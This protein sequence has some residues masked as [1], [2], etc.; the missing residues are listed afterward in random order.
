MNDSNCFKTKLTFFKEIYIEL[1]RVEKKIE[2]TLKIAL[3]SPKSP[4]FFHFLEKIFLKSNNL[5]TK[6]LVA[7]TIFLKSRFFLKS[8]F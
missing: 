8:K 7:G 4:Y 3:K 5:C 6:I 1:W 2:K